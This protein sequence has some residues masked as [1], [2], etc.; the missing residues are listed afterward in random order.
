MLRIT[1]YGHACVG[2][3]LRGK[4]LVI[5]PHDGYSI[6]LKRPEVKADYILVTHDHFDHNSVNIVSKSDSKI[7]K[8]REGEFEAEPFKIIGVRTFHDKERG[9]RRGVNIVYK[10]TTPGG[11]SILHAGDLG[12]VLTEDMLRSIGEVDI[13]IL[14]VGGTFT[15]DHVEA[16]DNFEKLRAKIMIPIHYWVKGV[17][18]PLSPIDPLIKEA[19]KRKISYTYS[20]TNYFEIEDSRERILGEKRIIILRY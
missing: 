17:N 8:M 11:V 14:P 10:V 12:H 13:A 2:I 18:L 3:S 6:G 4:I 5:D 19:E 15:I 1:W 7:F 16:L 9:K 20:D